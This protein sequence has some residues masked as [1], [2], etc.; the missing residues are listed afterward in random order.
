MGSNFYMINN[1]FTAQLDACYFDINATTCAEYPS[2]VNVTNI[3]LENI[4]S[5]TD[6]KVSD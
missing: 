6:G 3:T 2:R 5:I 4:N 1:D